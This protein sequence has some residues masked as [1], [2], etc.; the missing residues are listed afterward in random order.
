MNVVS[1][2][3]AKKNLEQLISEIVA[4]MEPLII[5]A[6]DG[7]QMVLLTMEEFSSWRETFYLLSTPANAAHLQRSILEAQTGKTIEVNLAELV[8]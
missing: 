2:P 3:E 6:D 8:D 1:V 4:S 5:T 7:Q